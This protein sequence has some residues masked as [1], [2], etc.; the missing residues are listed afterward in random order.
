MDI[1]I[2]FMKHLQAST[3][4]EI[5]HNNYPVSDATIQAVLDHCV[6]EEVKKGESII[7]KGKVCDYI[8][9]VLNGIFRV[10]YEND[11]K[12]ATLCFG[13]EGDPF[14]SLHSYHAGLP[15]QFS[16][17][18]IT[19]ATIA[20]IKFSDF[21]RLIDE[22]V[23]LNR[24]F[25]SVLV[26]QVFA[27]EARYVNLSGQSAYDR[28]LTLRRIRK[29]IINQIPLKYIA[30]YLNITPETLSRIRAEFAKK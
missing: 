30:Q 22:Y 9:F 13:T 17:E 4:K 6:V 23:D 14:M 12:E 24:W 20:K 2:I 29:E 7:S 5:L 19:N 28:Y 21:N 26:E 11:G 27:F 8:V 15:A 25:T 18:A 10:S 16:F 3:F 1:L